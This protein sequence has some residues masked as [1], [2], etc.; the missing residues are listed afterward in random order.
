MKKMFHKYL[1]K[2]VSQESLFWKFLERHTQFIQNAT[3]DLWKKKWFRVLTEFL[4][5]NKSIYF[6][7]IFQGRFQWNRILYN[8]ILYQIKQKSERFVQQL[9]CYNQSHRTYKFNHGVINLLIIEALDKVLK[10]I[11]AVSKDLL[12]IAWKC[13]NL[14][15]NIYIKNSKV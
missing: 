11:P 10:N 7:R 9:K 1:F 14:R 15:T 5:K 3:L 4:Q 2:D 8:W 6:P 13:N 12:R